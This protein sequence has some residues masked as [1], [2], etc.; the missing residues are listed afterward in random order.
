V[1]SVAVRAVAVIGE[2][3]GVAVPPGVDIAIAIA[4][5]GLTELLMARLRL[6]ERDPAAAGAIDP[7][8]P[9]L[10]AL[11]YRIVSLEWVGAPELGPAECWLF[12]TST[13]PGGDYSELAIG[14]TLALRIDGAGSTVLGVAF[15]EARAGADAVSR[16]ELEDLADDL[17]ATP[18]LDVTGLLSEVGAALGVDLSGASATAGVVEGTGAEPAIAVFV[19]TSGPV[20]FP[21]GARSFLHPRRHIA[22]AFAG[23][24][25]E[26]VAVP[27]AVAGQFGALPAEI[28]PGIELRSISVAVE[29]DCFRVDGTAAHALD[30]GVAI[31][32]FGGPV[33]I[34]YSQPSRSVR[35]DVDEI[36]AATP[37]SWLL[38]LLGPL[39]AFLIGW[40]DTM[41]NQ[42]V[43]DGV[44]R[45]FAGLLG[46]IDPSA[47]APSGG[48]PVGVVLRW[49]AIEDGSLVIG[50]SLH[51]GPHAA[52]VV[53][54]SGERRLTRVQL[55]DGDVLSILDAAD[56]VEEGVLELAD[57][58]V[59]RRATA[60]PY[61]R[62]DPDQQTGNNLRSLPGIAVELIPI[63]ERAPG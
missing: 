45:A 7:L 60:A 19:S 58:H 5:A 47:L 62:A 36:R 43:R 16:S 54:V 13:P 3:A 14:V 25:L 8:A 39:G 1:G 38:A 24:F 33:P 6:G 9:P 57:V 56:L 61:L 28:E 31:V 17:E 63:A 51:A 32:L 48:P 27:A 55:D 49:V 10:G 21:P 34:W 4:T 42:L 59:V 35:V 26:G 15:R 20:A 41:T 53:A 52:V 22:L 12:V 18:L 29:P 44:R 11:G 50:A 23:T 30:P 46:G 37:A 2:T 40:I